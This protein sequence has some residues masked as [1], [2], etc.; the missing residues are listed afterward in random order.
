MLSVR[1]EGAHH[2]SIE[3]VEQ[4][5]CPKL[6]SGVGGMPAGLKRKSF[7]ETMRAWLAATG[8]PANVSWMSVRLKMR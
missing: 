6:V 8:W 7:L 3:A 5:S 2:L 1:N 4:K